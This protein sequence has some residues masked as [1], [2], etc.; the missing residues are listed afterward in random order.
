M[1]E[2]CI[3]PDKDGTPKFK[4]TER[5]VF[6]DSPDRQKKEELKDVSPF[7]TR[8]LIIW[9]KSRAKLELEKREKYIADLKERLQYIAAT[10]LDKRR[11]E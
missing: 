2:G 9:S 7:W 4:V 5:S 11:Q 10:K 3:Y 6:I 1:L 8:C